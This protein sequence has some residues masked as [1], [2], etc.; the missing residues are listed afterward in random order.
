MKLVIDIPERWYETLVKTWDGIH[1]QISELI[2]YGTPLPKGHGRLIDAD[3]LIESLYDPATGEYKNP[4]LGDIRS[5]TTIIEADE[6][7]EADE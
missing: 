6:F 4:T 1:T 7:I 5:A 2:V 3:A